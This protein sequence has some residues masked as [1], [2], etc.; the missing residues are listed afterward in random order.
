MSATLRVDHVPMEVMIAVVP[1]AG[2]VDPISGLVRRLV[3]A[4]SATSRRRNRT[5]IRYAE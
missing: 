4:A 2:Y 3:R 1:V 5:F